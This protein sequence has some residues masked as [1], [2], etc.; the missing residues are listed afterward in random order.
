MKAALIPTAILNR[1]TTLPNPSPQ[2]GGVTVPRPRDFTF[3]PTARGIEEEGKT[4]PRS[5][6]SPLWGGFGEGF[7]QHQMQVR[8]DGAMR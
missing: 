3:A 1:G 2:G 8:F 5:G 6:A 7:R 4:M